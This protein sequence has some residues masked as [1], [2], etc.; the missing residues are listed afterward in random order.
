VSCTF[1][2]SCTDSFEGLKKKFAFELLGISVR[3]MVN[4]TCVKQA[5]RAA[6]HTNVFTGNLGKDVR[7]W[8]TQ[9][10]DLDCLHNV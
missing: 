9:S 10:M 2:N 1:P 6:A 5:L 3:I 4:L 7:H 8:L